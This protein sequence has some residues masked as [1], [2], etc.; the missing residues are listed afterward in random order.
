MP[1]NSHHGVRASADVTHLRHAYGRANLLVLTATE[2]TALLVDGDHVI[3]VV[4]H[5]AAGPIRIIAGQVVLCAGA[6]DTAL[7]E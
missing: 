1:R 5:D 4:A 7:D 6:E 3:G 2:V